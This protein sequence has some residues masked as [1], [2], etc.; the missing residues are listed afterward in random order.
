MHHLQEQ[1]EI[2]AIEH[3]RANCKSRA[4]TQEFANLTRG[5]LGK[6][7][8]ARDIVGRD[9]DGCE[10]GEARHIRWR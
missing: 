1:Q 9:V 2:V 6:M 8:R 3:L 10:G 7:K 5:A 4:E